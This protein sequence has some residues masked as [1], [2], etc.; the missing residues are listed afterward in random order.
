MSSS[1]LSSLTRLRVQWPVFTPAGKLASWL[2]AYVDAQDLN[3]WCMSAILP[4]ETHFDEDAKLW[5][6]TVS[7]AGT[8]RHLSVK[9]VVLATGM[10]GGFP[11]LPAPWVDLFWARRCESAANMYCSF[12]GQESYTGRLVH[13]SQHGSGRNWTGKRALVVGACTSAH[14]VRRLSPP[15]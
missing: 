2:E 1:V 5:R 12:P 4:E 10:S 7:R 6:V 8:K 3:V 14:D 9:H 11:R 13:S 15:L